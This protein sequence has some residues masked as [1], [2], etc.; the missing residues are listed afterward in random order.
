MLRGPLKVRTANEP[1]QEGAETVKESQAEERD[2]V[3]QN[4]A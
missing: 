2:R 4:W 1:L 3:L